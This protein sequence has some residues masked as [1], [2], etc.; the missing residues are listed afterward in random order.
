M[1]YNI[2]YICI[3]ISLLHEYYICLKCGSTGSRVDKKAFDKMLFCQ[4]PQRQAFTSLSK[5]MF[6][7]DLLDHGLA[8]VEDDGVVEGLDHLLYLPL[9]SPHVAQKMSC[10]K[11]LEAVFLVVCDPPMND[12]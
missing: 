1:Y 9:L 7:T 6:V 5:R 3:I 2:Y 8:D 12:L 4:E 10:G 11:K